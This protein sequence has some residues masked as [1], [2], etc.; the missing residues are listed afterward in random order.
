MDSCRQDGTWTM[1]KGVAIEVSLL[2]GKGE[3]ESLTRGEGS[4]GILRPQE[5]AGKRCPCAVPGA[6][7]W[8][9]G[10]KGKDADFCNSPEFNALRLVGD[11]WGKSY[12]SGGKNAPRA[13]TNE[14]GGGK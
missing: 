10:G 7:T 6:D 3:G 5:R 9:E 14:R 2:R 13:R 12:R 4:E 1:W 8:R 11:R